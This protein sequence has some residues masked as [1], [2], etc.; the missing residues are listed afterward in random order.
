MPPV[1]ELR[2][3]N[4]ISIPPPIGGLNVKDA[5]GAMSRTDAIVLTNWIPQQYGVRCRKG[6]KE[7][8]IGLGG[9]VLSMCVYQPNRQI[10][11][12]YQLFGI[13]NNGIF[14]VT[15]PTNL[16]VSSFSLSGATDAGRFSSTMFTN[17][18]G[19]FLLACSQAGGYFTY[20][21]IGW[22]QRASGTESGYIDNVDPNS[23]VFV[24]SWKRRVWFVER[25]STNAW[26]LPT[27]QIT[28]AAVK[29]ELGPFVKHGGRLAFITN[30]TIDAGEGIDDLI[31]FAFEGGDILIY[32]GTNPD[33][34]DS[35]GLVGSYYIGQ[36]PIGRR[37]YGAFGGDVLIIS[38]LGLQPLSYVTRGGQSILR[39]ESTDYLDKIQPRV[40]EY[41]SQLAEY[42]GWEIMLY[43]RENL[44]L[45]NIPPG[46]TIL[47]QQ[48]AMY[49]NTNQWCMFEDVPIVSAV[50]AAD[51]FWFGTSDGRVCQGFTGY[52]DNVPYGQSTGN[53]ITGVI[54]PAYSYF[55]S[56]GIHKQFHLLRPTFLSSDQPGVSAAIMVDF[57]SPLLSNAPVSAVAKGSAW[58]VALWDQGIWNGALNRFADWIGLEGIGFAGS[59]YIVTNCTGDTLLVSLD[60][61]FEPLPQGM[62]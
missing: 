27:D 59:P 49:T 19:A 47:K 38:E 5:L 53:G 13:T 11:N 16:P 1:P 50:V 37:G 43:P 42:D 35:F 23:L 57:N 52:F 18:A 51:S 55:G 41:V 4:P 30:W 2:R 62:I 25:D 45:V 40:A 12:S 24:T 44:L 20:D 15:D 9:E 61:I 8:A 60:I 58:D 3:S 10:A 7:H 39:T 33:S 34:A 31:V 56:S 14:D 29:F 32:K 36:L 21:G 54:Q 26:Y 48:F 28:G 46:P 6:Y 17:S 22:Q